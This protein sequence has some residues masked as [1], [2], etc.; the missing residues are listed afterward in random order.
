MTSA[1]Y[2]KQVV[3]TLPGR[4]GNSRVIHPTTKMLS[5]AVSPY[6][7][8]NEMQAGYMFLNCNALSHFYFYRVGFF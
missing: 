3:A 6:I 1:I 4:T 8:V 5:I 2:V 7:A